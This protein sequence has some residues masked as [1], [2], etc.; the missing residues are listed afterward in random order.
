MNLDKSF[1]WHYCVK[2]YHIGTAT[3]KLYGMRECINCNSKS[4]GEKGFSHTLSARMLNEIQRN[5]Q[6][7]NNA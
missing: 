2:C 3:I 4:S 6:K 7:Q 5:K 1:E